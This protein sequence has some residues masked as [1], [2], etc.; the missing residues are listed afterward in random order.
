LTSS[1]S[2]PPRD[3]LRPCSWKCHI[4]NLCYRP[5]FRFSIKYRQPGSLWVSTHE[6][7]DCS[8]SSTCYSRMS[9]ERP[10]LCSE[11]V[12]HSRSL[13]SAKLIVLGCRWLLQ[14]PANCQSSCSLVP[15]LQTAVAA[16]AASCIWRPCC[17][18]RPR[19]ADLRYPEERQVVATK[20]L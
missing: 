11:P 6:S 18:G 10:V 13:N 12:T 4:N 14:L 9:C 15:L 5:S 16:A 7:L 8:F 1:S 19:P 2:F 3:R 17:S 20:R